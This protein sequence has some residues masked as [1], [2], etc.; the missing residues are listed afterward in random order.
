MAGKVRKQMGKKDTQTKL[1]MSDP[2]HF[3]DAFNSSVF[4]GKQVVHADSL[5]LQ[6]MDS[7]ELQQNCWVSFFESST[8]MTLP[9]R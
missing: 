2:K 6:E 4:K 7:T 8:L 1:Y 9:L 3:A 5:S